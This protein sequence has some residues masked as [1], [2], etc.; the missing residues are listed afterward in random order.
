MSVY[1]RQLVNSH[2]RDVITN[3]MLLNSTSF[4]PGHERL[5]CFSFIGRHILV[6]E[7]C[8]DSL[9]PLPEM[10]VFTKFDLVQYNFTPSDVELPCA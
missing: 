8:E 3:P 9:N 10:R 6:V 7:K 1:I 4:F 2:L 5:L